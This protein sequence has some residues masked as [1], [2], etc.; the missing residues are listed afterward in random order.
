MSTQ[1]VS[2]ETIEDFLAQKRI[3]MVGVSRDAKDFSVTL[4]NE[5]CRRGYEVVPV[6]PVT[7]ELWGRRCFARVQEITPTSG[8]S[9]VDDV[10]ECDGRSG[11]RL[12]GG[13]SSAGMDVPGRR[14]RC[15]EYQC[16][17]FL[18]RQRDCSCAGRVSVYVSAGE[19]IS[20]D[21]WVCPVDRGIVTAACAGCLVRLMSDRRRKAAHRRDALSALRKSLDNLA[22]PQEKR[23]M[24]PVAG[25]SGEM[26]R[27]SFPAC[28][29]YGFGGEV[30]AADGAFHSRG[31]S[32]GGPVSGEKDA[33]PERG[34][35]W[36]V[37]VDAGTRG[38]GGVEFLD[39]CGFDQV[40]FAGTG[41][42]FADLGEG[43]VDDFGAGFVDQGLGGADDELDV[44]AL[45]AEAPFSAMLAR[46][47]P[48]FHSFYRLD[49][50]RCARRL[51]AGFVEHPLDGAVEKNGVVEIGDLA[52]EPEMD[53]GDGGGFEVGDFSLS[54]SLFGVFGR[55]LSRAS[56]GSARIRKSKSPPLPTAGRNWA[57]AGWLFV[58]LP[59]CGVEVGRAM[60]SR[61]ILQ[62]AGGNSISPPRARM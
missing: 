57:S 41:E 10:A 19:R 56:K 52:I 28:A 30:S 29:S 9:A 21:S 53:S 61:R 34:G 26:K 55:T 49:R 22:R 59:D 1:K 62:P 23:R 50:A 16:S 3:A 37:G 13:R 11:S 35:A 46:P 38:I 18:P 15:G 25:R 43:Q 36:T 54:G 33:R 44:A 51:Q 31:P 8:R 14:R 42:K 20:Q 24:R 58:S 47:R 48:L 17:R 12:R 32:G 45:G 2:L 40:R 6:N 39:D 4:F 7:T 27:R 60:R 5:L